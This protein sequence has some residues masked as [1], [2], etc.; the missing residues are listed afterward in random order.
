[1]RQAAVTLYLVAPRRG[2]LP[3]LLDGFMQRCREAGVE[4]EFVPSPA[5]D[6]E[7][8]FYGFEEKQNHAH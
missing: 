6:V 8:A 3:E 4:F 1:M 2:V 5:S 7:L